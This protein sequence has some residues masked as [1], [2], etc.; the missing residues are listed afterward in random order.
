MIEILRQY[1]S[2]LLFGDY[3]NGPLGGLAM[4]LLLSVVC[5]AITLPA[6]T[7]IALA[8]TSARPLLVRISIGF[9]YAVRAMP[10]LMLVFWIYYFLPD[11]LGFTISPFATMLIAISLYQTG[12]LSEVIRAAIEALPPGQVDAA[13][14]LGLHYWLTTLRIVLPQALANCMPGLLNQFTQ[15][16]KETSLGYV[17]TFNEVTYS[18]SQLNSILLVHPVEIFG[19]LALTYFALCSGLS[20]LSL[21]W[22]RRLVARSARR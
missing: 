10:L 14:A 8:R 18:A 17:I 22:E 21:R 5:L 4:T 11:V 16:I 12:Y 3:P 6:A 13:R 2:L 15:L 9:V 19:I 7:G 1:G 20:Q